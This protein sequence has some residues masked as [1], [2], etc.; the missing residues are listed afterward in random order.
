LVAR[1]LRAPVDCREAAEAR[2]RRVHAQIANRRLQRSPEPATV[3]VAC[4]WKW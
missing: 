1:A 2:A 4:A 3:R